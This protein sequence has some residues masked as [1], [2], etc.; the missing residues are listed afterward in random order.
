MGAVE[1]RPCA[2]AAAAAGHDTNQHAALVT[3]D[4]SEHEL[5][6]HSHTAVAVGPVAA[7][8]EYDGNDAGQM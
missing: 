7:A 4:P 5:V 2:A 3:P 8:G 6:R 1:A